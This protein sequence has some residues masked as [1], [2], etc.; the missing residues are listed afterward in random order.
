L[1]QNHGHAGKPT[2][3][4]VVVQKNRAIRLVSGRESK[5]P[6][7]PH[8]RFPTGKHISDARVMLLKI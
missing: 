3:I 7:F 2:A 5:Q 4:P 6:I 1:P 8:V